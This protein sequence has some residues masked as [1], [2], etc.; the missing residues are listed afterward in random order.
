MPEYFQLHS[1]QG[2]LSLGGAPLYWRAPEWLWL[3]GIPFLLWLG[4]RLHRGWQ[5]RRYADPALLPWLVYRRPRRYGA[6]L[7]AWPAAWSGVWPKWAL[8]L[9]WSLLCIALA[10]P[11]LALELL[12]KAGSHKPEIMLAIDLSRSMNAADIAP[13]RRQRAII[14]IH[15]WLQHLQQ[16]YGATRTAEGLGSG[17]RLGLVVFAGRAHVLLPPTADY[18]VV[19]FYLDTLAHLQLPTRGSNL[20]AALDTAAT[21][22]DARATRRAI[23]LISDGGSS[24]RLASSPAGGRAAE[25]AADTALI[26]RARALAARHIRVSALG[27]GTAAGAGIPL[28][29]G[30]WLRARGQAVLSRLN[31]SLLTRLARAGDGRYSPV[32]DD[33]SDWRRIDA[34]GLAPALDLRNDAYNDARQE[35]GPAANQ[36][37]WRTLF[38]YALL[39]AII[40]FFL[41][42][43]AWLPRW[44]GRAVHSDGEDEPGRSDLSTADHARTAPNQGHTHRRRRPG[45]ATRSGV[46][47]CG[48]GL[49][50]ASAAMLSPRPALASEQNAHAAYQQQQYATA[51]ALYSQQ[52]GYRAR[53][54]EGDSLYRL[55]QYAGAIRQFTLATLA[56]RT[57]RQRANALFN[58]GNSHFQL[59]DYARAARVF[60]DVL[61]YRAPDPAAAHNRALSTALAARV[62]QDLG[63]GRGGR[64]GS[65]PRQ[66]RAPAGMNVDAQ[67]RLSISDATPNTPVNDAATPLAALSRTRLDALLLRGLN[68]ARLATGAAAQADTRA[69]S[70][71]GREAAPGGNAAVA[72]LQDG[73][74]TADTGAQ[75]A[76]LWQRIFEDEEGFPAPLAQPKTLPGLAPW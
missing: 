2:L 58:L 17:P 9:A 56:A 50:L 15:E 19:R 74:A 26:A 1:L 20:L 54:G 7:S 18:R 55:R 12:G 63:G 72:L 30:G 37:I 31:S 8:F 46:V 21:G 65:G 32:E 41:A 4:Q 61:R 59:G 67:A 36:V 73:Q 40:A 24:G 68:R 29:G 48:L 45:P 34:T 22:F 42:T 53:M 11:R 13:S 62:Q 76:R 16:R 38:P 28:S 39:P 64:M 60:S 70:G 10:G 66:A 69:P 25:A 27:I 23:I 3:L 5:R 52:R 47:L 44:R 75:T 43:L 6:P 51:R 35:R 49:G 33:A 57:D 71:T 14:E